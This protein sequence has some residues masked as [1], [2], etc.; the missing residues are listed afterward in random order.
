MRL[1]V[2][3]TPEFDY[4]DVV[5]AHSTSE[6]VCMSTIWGWLRYHFRSDPTT[7]VAGNLAWYPDESDDGTHCTPDVMV[8][9]D[10]PEGAHSA[11]REQGGVGVS[12][13]VVFEV[14]SSGGR[15]DDFVRW[16]RSDAHP[17]AADITPAMSPFGPRLTE[18]V[19]KLR[20]YESHG[21]EE[22]YVYDPD[23]R[24]LF[25]WCR[26]GE[27]LEQLETMDGWV[28]PRLG[29][30]F[31]LGPAG[32]EFYSPRGTRLRSH[33]DLVDRAERFAARLRELGIEPD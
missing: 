31:R 5:G 30:R 18:L 2:Q 9:F 6:F 14:L 28:S 3:P 32:F 33:A 29:V 26:A 17:G 4:S 15:M 22:C 23:R 19:R 16:Y 25:G 1:A 13:Q 8:I 27:G 20:R 7:V 12:P 11:S 10:Q 24:S 21:V